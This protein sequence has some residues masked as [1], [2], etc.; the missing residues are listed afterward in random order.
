[1][2]ETAPP[3]TDQ[4]LTDMAASWQPL[5]DSV[6]QRRQPAPATPERKGN[7]L[8]RIF[9]GHRGERQPAREPAP[10]APPAAEAPATAERKKAWYQGLAQWSWRMTGDWAKNLDPRGKDKAWLIGMGLGTGYGLALNLAVPP[11]ADRLV[12]SAVKFAASQALYTGIKGYNAY[13]RAILTNRGRRHHASETEINE[14]LERVELRRSRAV[15]FIRN[16]GLGMAA[17]ATYTSITGAGLG[18]AEHF[19]GARMPDVF[20]A[21]GKLAEAGISKAKE[22]IESP[23]QIGL[24]EV[25]LP[26]V[27]LPQ[28]ELPDVFGA[29]GK[30]FQEITGGDTTAAPPLE[31]APAAPVAPATPTPEVPPVPTVNQEAI[32]AAVGAHLDVSNQMVDKAIENMGFDPKDI[33]QQAYE[34]ARLAVQH[35]MEDAANFYFDPAVRTTE[36]ATRVFE[37]SITD[38]NGMAAMQQ[39]AEAGLKNSLLEEMTGSDSFREAAAAAVGS[40]LDT[41][42]DSTVNEVL[43]ARGLDPSKLSPETLQRLQNALQNQL[44][45]FAGKQFANAAEGVIGQGSLDPGAVADQGNKLLADFL[46]GQTAHD[47]LVEAAAKA[48]GPT[49]LTSFDLSSVTS[50][51]VVEKIIPQGSTVG[52]MLFEA[53]VQ[54]GWGADNANLFAAEIAANY[55][56]LGSPIP[57]D[58]LKSLAEAAK[59]G[60]VEALKKLHAALRWVPAGAKLKILTNAGVN[61]VLAGLPG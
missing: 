24:P 60:D 13:E 3:G 43:A 55:D 8:G 18:A 14:A 57:L 1:M 35:D 15:K 6:N 27:S 40:H 50:S 54:T 25:K 44:E 33:S 52:H 45:E 37:Q 5:I 28:P 48:L 47:E 12:A 53:G 42:V 7:L 23:P 56:L 20:G 49:Q 31:A 59:N 39:I 58:E 16:F 2:A 51:N 46:A 29:A 17:G 32:A 34:Q 36:I 11:G 21:A 19:L 9:G 61:D 30:K 26:E 41:V 22:T 38:P 4:E 10:T